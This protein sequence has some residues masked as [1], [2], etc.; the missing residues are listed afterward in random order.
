LQLFDVFVTVRNGMIDL[1]A[2]RDRGRCL[3]EPIEE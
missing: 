3:H 2:L 1:R